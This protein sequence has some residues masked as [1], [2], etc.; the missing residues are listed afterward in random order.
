MSLSLMEQNSS[1]QSNINEPLI[2]RYQPS[3]EKTSQA[4]LPLGLTSAPSSNSSPL[5]GSSSCSLFSSTIQLPN[6]SSNIESA[7]ATATA[8][9]ISEETIQG[10]KVEVDEDESVFSPSTT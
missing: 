3:E 1:D 2:L 7:T 9:A 5:T 8:T 10:A 6:V 4:S